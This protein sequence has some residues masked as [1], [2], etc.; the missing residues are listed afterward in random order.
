MSQ[1]GPKSLGC[2]ILRKEISVFKAFGRRSKGPQNKSKGWLIR[3]PNFVDAKNLKPFYSQEFFGLIRL[4]ELIGKNGKSFDGYNAE[5]IPEVCD[6]YLSARNA[7]VLTKQ[8]L[9]LTTAS[10]MLVRSL[11]LQWLIDLIGARQHQW[12][13]HLGDSIAPEDYYLTT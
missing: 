9:P 4:V 1:Y 2:P 7:N 5:I 3:V 8:Q 12:I 10:E 13:F 6:V 11:N